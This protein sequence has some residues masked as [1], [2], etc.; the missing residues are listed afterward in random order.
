MS[1]KLQKL[2]P[3]ECKDVIARF[4]R[5]ND[6]LAKLG[7]PR[8][9]VCFEGE[10]GVG[11]TS[12]PKQVAKDLGMGFKYLVLSQIEDIGDLVGYPFLAVQMK[13]DEDSTTK[14]GW[15]NQQFASIQ[16]SN[17]WEYTGKSRTEYAAPEWV[18]D[19]HQWDKS[20]LVIDDFTR[21]DPRFQQAIMQ[22]IQMGSYYSWSLPLGTT[23]VLTAN[24]NDGDYIV[25]D[26]DLAMLGRYAKF[27]IKFDINDW[28]K[29]ATEIGI[30]GRCINIMIHSYRELMYEKDP[31]KN[32]AGK[33]VASPRDWSNFFEFIA[34]EDSFDSTEAKL[35]I[36]KYGRS[37]VGDMVDAFLV[38]LTQNIDKIPSPEEVLFD[39]WKK[40]ESMLETCCGI[41]GHKT[42]KYKPEYGAVVAMR[43]QYYLL[44]FLRDKALK[45]K[46]TDKSKETVEERLNKIFTSPSISKDSKSGIMR[47]IFGEHGSKLSELMMQADYQETLLGAH[48]KKV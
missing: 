47:V 6:R 8:L 42:N 34:I 44:S 26:Q 1:S 22:L 13:R 43:L 7:R 23:I 48:M 24:P 2:S 11:K 39:D 17:G 12:I 16:E 5:A 41:V 20:L 15:F 29:W 19:L 46:L 3:E 18:G 40:V 38:S 31:E 21:A 30:D 45:D 32:V 25:N 35:S 9:S 28:A 10:A 14:F 33:M 4:I 37:F 36:T 27:G